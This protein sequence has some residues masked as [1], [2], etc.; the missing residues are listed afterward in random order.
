VAK[1]DEEYRQKLKT[2]YG[3]QIVMLTP[4]QLKEV[5]KQVRKTTWPKMEQLVGKELMDRIYKES[6]IPRQ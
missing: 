4:A 1:E 3:W 5:A 6:K 2:E